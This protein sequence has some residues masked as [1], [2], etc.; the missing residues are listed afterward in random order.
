[1]RKSK[2][3]YRYILSAIADYLTDTTSNWH[4]TQKVAGYVRSRIGEKSLPKKSSGR[5]FETLYRK[6][7]FTTA[8]Q[9][10]KSYF[11]YI[12]RDK[13]WASLNQMGGHI[14]SGAK[15]LQEEISASYSLGGQPVTDEFFKKFSSRFT[16]T[17]KSVTYTFRGHAVPPELNDLVEAVLDSDG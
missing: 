2:A 5:I 12:D 3:P 6:G 14:S 10:K 15:G 11:V 17:E 7:I 9:G 16:E 4:N 1:M 13:L 8:T